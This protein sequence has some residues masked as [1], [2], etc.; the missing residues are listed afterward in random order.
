MDQSWN[1]LRWWQ[2]IQVDLIWCII[3]LRK[4]ESTPSK[5]SITFG[6]ILQQMKFPGNLRKS[7]VSKVTPHPQFGQRGVATAFLMWFFPIKSVQSFD[8]FVISKKVDIWY[9]LISRKFHLLQNWSKSYAIFWWGSF[10]LVKHYY[11]PNQINLYWLS[12]PQ[13]ILRLVHLQQS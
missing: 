4:W 9:S 3:M 11:T 12:P 2:P 1:P 6:P 7:D 8:N 10:P 13:R 5:Y